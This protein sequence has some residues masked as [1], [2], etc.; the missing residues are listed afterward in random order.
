V[1]AATLKLRVTVTV[2][3]GLADELGLAVAVAD[4]EVDGFGVGLDVVPLTV[5]TTG[6]VLTPPPHAVRVATTAITA[7]QTP[8]RNDSRLTEAMMPCAIAESKSKCY[9]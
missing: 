5:E 8:V 6:V 7:K 2:P 1:P 3:V 4:A 9:T